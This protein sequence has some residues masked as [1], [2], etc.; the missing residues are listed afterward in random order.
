[1]KKIIALGVFCLFIYTA[2]VA[3]FD[4]T[5]L[6]KTTMYSSSLFS[7]P[8]EIILPVFSL[9]E[10]E[11]LDKNDAKNGHLAL[12][13]RNINTNITLHNSGVWNDLPDGSRVWR[14]KITSANAL[15]LVPLFDRFYLPQGATLHVYMPGK[16]EVLG[17][18]THDNSTEV[19]AF[20]SGIIHGET[21][22]VEYNEP[23]EVK[24]KGIISINQIGHAYRWITPLTRSAN[25][26]TA[27]GAC[28]V[29]VVCSEAANWADQ[30]RSAARILV[31]SASG[32]GFCSGAL[33]NNVRAD[34]TPYF[35]SAQHCS[36]GTTANQYT[37]WVFYFNYQ[38]ATCNGTTG[39]TNKIVNGC[40]KIADS[41]DN[42]GDTGPDFLLLRFNSNVPVSYN[43]YFSGWNHLTTPSPSG[44]SIH[45]P[46][47]DIKK[48]STYTTPLTTTSW[49]GSVNNTHWDVKWA[50]T[51]NGH[52][53]TEPGSS[54]S[55]LFNN[56]QQIIGTLTGGD[57]YCATPNNK[58]QYGRVFYDW[59]SMGTAANRQLKIWLDPDNTAADSIGGANAPCG[60][61]VQNDAGVLSI[62]APTENICNVA[63][64]VS[65]TPKI[66]IRNFGANTITT[67]I[68]NYTI[69]GN[70]FQYH[71]TGT[72]LS[73]NTTTITL[74]AIVLGIGSHTFIFETTLPNNQTDGNTANDIQT[75][76]IQIFPPSA[77]VIL[78]LHTDDYGS[79]THWE[80][81]NANTQIVAEGGTY[82]DVN[83]GQAIVETACLATGCYTF[84]IYDSYGDGI[85][86]GTVG[87]FTLSGNGTTYATLTSPNFGT[88]EAH[89]FCVIAT[90]IEESKTLKV[91]VIPNPSNGV[92]SLRFDEAQEKSVRVFDALGRIV[93]EKKTSEQNFSIDLS[94]ASKGVYI[95]ET[96]S[97]LGKAEQKLI[98]K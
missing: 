16:Q 78:N 62:T 7:K 67:I 38:A 96:Q 24:G 91:N 17:A 22:I 46:D 61:V 95:L 94:A 8:Q 64:T 59:T 92:F 13:S 83:G 23:S 57:S 27:A 63:T 41:N 1:M 43:A 56:H 73:G 36:E 48:I 3:Q 45:H 5:I 25:S 34:C 51:A 90:S 40:T 12:F 21:C 76:S 33:I 97:S 84:T 26:S 14:V 86:S 68:I 50:A 98:L 44:V 19:R 87:S 52:G 66:V 88:Q 72:L 49:G 10:A 2:V 71:F 15:A 58:D 70:V 89:N 37:Q 81:T 28:E 85:S 9:A 79:E 53:V 74:P 39:P 4:E 54:G 60:T 75:T 42:G 31:V 65:D 29:N 32:N 80:I 18:F 30:V 77:S 82:T 93:F 6:P 69:D 11:Q 47:G 55:P 35:L 20:C